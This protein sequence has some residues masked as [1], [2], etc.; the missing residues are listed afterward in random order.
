MKN[1]FNRTT[2]TKK[3][4]EEIDKIRKER[5]AKR[6]DIRLRGVQAGAKIKDKLGYKESAKIKP[7]YMGIILF[8][9]PELKGQ[10]DI[11]Y[12]VFAGRTVNEIIVSKLD[13]LLEKIKHF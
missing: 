7:N 12:R 9:Y 5:R 1:I 11:I 8:E 6:H 4:S 10:E 2:G 13:D 3:S